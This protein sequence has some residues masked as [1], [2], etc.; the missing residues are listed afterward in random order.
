MKKISVL[1]IVFLFAV[2]A[3]SFAGLGI[4]IN[5]HPSDVSVGEN[6]TVT[7]YVVNTGNTKVDYVTPS[8]LMIMGNGYASPMNGPVPY[9]V[10][11]L[12]PG[13][14]VTFTWIYFA[15]MA[16]SVA[17]SGAAGGTDTGTA[18]QV[19][20]GDVIS[21]YVNILDLPVA[22]ETATPILMPTDT[23]VNTPIIMPTDTPEVTP[24]ST[25]EIIRDEDVY[26]NKNY[27][28]PAKGD[29][30]I[31]TFK[32]PM[33]GKVYFKIFNLSGEIL[34]AEEINYAGGTAQADWDAKNTAGNTVGKGIYF[35]MIKQGKWQVMKKVVILK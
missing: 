35:I 11:E 3:S 28:E 6:I 12:Q 16:G 2:S 19:N 26:T 21:N 27:I 33:Q 29:K 25:P 5:A 32:A 14:S 30:L 18:L 8:G 31:V 24:T 34:K 15:G 1:I 9:N 22:T 7:M 17:F 13:Y 10:P 4:E 23:P 20:S